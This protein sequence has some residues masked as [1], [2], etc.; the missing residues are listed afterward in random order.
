MDILIEH[1]KEHPERQ[2]G[3][4]TPLD[5]SIVVADEYLTI[6]RYLN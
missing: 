6:H 1:T 3:F 2:F 5:A 4:L